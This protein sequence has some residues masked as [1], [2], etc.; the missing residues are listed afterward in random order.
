LSYATHFAPWGWVI[1]T[2]V[3]ISDVDEHYRK[4]AVTLGSIGILLIALISILGWRIGASILGQLGGEPA[5]A[6]AIMRQVA[7]GD[8]TAVASAPNESL[9]GNLSSMVATLRNLVKA[10]NEEANGLVHHAE[11]IRHGA[12][13]VARAS[14]QQSDATSSMAAAIEELTVSSNHISDSARDTEQ[15]SRETMTLATDGNLRVGEASAAIQTVADVVTQASERIRSLEDRARKISSVANVIKEIADQTNL[16]ALNAAIEAARAGEQGRGFAVVADEVRKL[17][18]RTAIATTEIET[19]IA[20][21]QDDTAASVGAMDAVLP[22]VGEGV[23][24]ANHA[25]EALRKIESGTSRSL[26]HVAEVANSTAEQSAAS[27]SIA[28]QVEQVAI[29]VEQ[30]NRTIQG[31]VQSSQELEQI[32]LKLKA[33]ISQFKV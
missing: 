25:A 29:M 15:D 33:Q 5:A 2:G 28:K 11:Q 12:D 13:Q 17:A 16:L 8:L 9:L 24:L 10:I 31:T 26:T 1:G 20:G 27:T 7:A 3:Y 32:S 18:E 4:G 6:A 22:K 14:A 30:T 19:M 21:I 23:Q